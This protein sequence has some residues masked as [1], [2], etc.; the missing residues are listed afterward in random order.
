M[1]E[2]DQKQPLDEIRCSKKGKRGRPKDPDA[3]KFKT[4]GLF[5]WQ[6]QWLALWF[7]DGN[8]T[9]QAQ[10]LLD[11]AVKFWPAGPAKFR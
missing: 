3:L 9:N 5:E 8:P 2:S 4:I 1:S 6:W 11:R 10:E 7:P